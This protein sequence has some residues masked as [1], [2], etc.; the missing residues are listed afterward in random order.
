MKPYYAVIFTS[1]LTEQKKGYETMA[2]AMETL[3]E[4]QPGFLSFESARNELGISVSYWESEQAIL[5][6][7][8][9]LDHLK[10]QALGKSK[11]YD[12]YTIRICKVEREYS[13]SR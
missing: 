12:R 9:Q 1:V 3:A 6:W 10:A 11:W 13:F 5:D 2:V 7:K 4:K 8:Q